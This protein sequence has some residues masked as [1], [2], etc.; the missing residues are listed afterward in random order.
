MGTGC[1]ELGISMILPEDLGAIPGKTTT[2]TA[3]R[4]LLKRVVRP[5]GEKKKHLKGAGLL[6]RGPVSAIFQVPS[7]AWGF[8]APGPKGAILFGCRLE[9][10]KDSVPQNESLHASFR[11]PQ[12]SPLEPET[13]RFGCQF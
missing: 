6:G 7:F 13:S 4:C 8:S 11:D 3:A 12:A 5:P 9:G 10:N 1:H 2:T